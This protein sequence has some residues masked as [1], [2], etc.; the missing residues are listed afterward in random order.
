MGN[1]FAVLLLIISGGAGGGDDDYSC[2]T[3][4]AFPS[5]ERIG[6]MINNNDKKK[7][8]KKKKKDEIRLVE[9]VVK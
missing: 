6:K 1:R 8:K 7:K 2:G 4:V 9:E 5:L 3:L